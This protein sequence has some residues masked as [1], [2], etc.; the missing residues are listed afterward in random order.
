MA[1]T[2]I[3]VFDAHDLKNALTGGTTVPATVS[4][5]LQWSGTTSRKIFNDPAQGFMADFAQNSATIEWSAKQVGFT[6]TSD[7][8]ATSQSTFAEVGHERNGLA[9]PLSAS[10]AP[11]RGGGSGRW[12]AIPE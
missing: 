1:I 4:W 3:P 6:F 8:A 10:L 2:N 7:P 11:G 5:K 12:G 9:I